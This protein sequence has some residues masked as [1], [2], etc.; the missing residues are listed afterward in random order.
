MSSHGNKSINVDT[1]IDF[2]DITIFESDGLFLK[3]R[4]VT[5]NFIDRNT[6]WESDAFLNIFLIVDFC[7]LIR[8]KFFTS[9]T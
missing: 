9:S 7:Q 4:K 5:T 8:G 3:W 2:G 6:N 1:K